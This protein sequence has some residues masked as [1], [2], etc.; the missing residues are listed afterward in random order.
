MEYV[1]MLHGSTFMSKLEL[2]GVKTSDFIKEET[3]RRVG[4]V[5]PILEG[6]STETPPRAIARERN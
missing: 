5:S 2:S 3:A 1:I 6:G 4:H